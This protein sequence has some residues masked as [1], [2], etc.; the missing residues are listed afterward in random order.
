MKSKFKDYL[1]YTLS[2]IGVFALFITATTKPTNEVGTFQ[3]TNS[4]DGGFPI[5]HKINTQT[6]EMWRWDRKG[7]KNTGDW[8]IME[9]K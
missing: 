3:I 8:R 7:N 9:I 1:L 5:I 4:S 6:G 2:T